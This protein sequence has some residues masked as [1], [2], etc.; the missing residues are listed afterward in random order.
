LRT[1][2]ADS[3]SDDGTF[4]TGRSADRAVRW[5]GDGPPIDLGVG[6]TLTV[7][8]SGDGSIA[9]GTN[10]DGPSLEAFRWTAESGA[11]PLEQL[12]GLDNVSPQDMTPDGR[13]I[14]GFDQGE[15]RG[16]RRTAGG[17]VDALAFTPRAVSDDG[18]IVA[19]VVSFGGPLALWTEETGTVDI[20]QFL[21]GLGLDLTG[22]RLTEVTAIS[23]D[24][25]TI[26]GHGIPP[27]PSMSGAWIATIPEPSTWLLAGT[28]LSATVIGI[29][30]R[31]RTQRP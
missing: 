7:L 28:S 14:V 6:T 9:I 24:G 21:T 20:Q 8:T 30:L 12:I 5:M 1:S 29:L 15:S 16:F 25:T 2:H 10:T 26:A 17:G 13:V 18:R 31:R 3:V 4:I 22:W 27:D 11:V 23:G 19:G